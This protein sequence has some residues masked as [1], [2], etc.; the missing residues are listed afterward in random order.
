MNGDAATLWNNDWIAN[1]KLVA[2]MEPSKILIKPAVE[3][4]E[5]VTPAEVELFKK[6]AWQY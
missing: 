5:V 3:T 4:P 2:A 6:N 1:G